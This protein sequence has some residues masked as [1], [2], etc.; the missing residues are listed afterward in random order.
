[1]IKVLFREAS[2]RHLVFGVLFKVFS[3]LLSFISVPLILDCLS[4]N[5][6]GVWITLS[7]LIVWVQFFDFGLKAAQLRAQVYNRSDGLSAFVVSTAF[8]F[9]LDQ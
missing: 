6:Y 9:V 2:N 7:S 8:Q 5:D 3:V 1:M 4:V